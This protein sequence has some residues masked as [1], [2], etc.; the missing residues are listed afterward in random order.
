MVKAF[1]TI[2]VIFGVLLCYYT[3]CLFVNRTQ[4]E[5]DSKLIK[6]V[7]Y[8]L[9]WFG[10]CALS[11]NSIKDIYIERVTHQSK[12]GTYFTFNIVME[13]ID[14]QTVKVMR[15]LQNSFQ[16]LK[17]EQEVKKFLRSF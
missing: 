6:A 15:G 14:D 11:R 16:A 3:V 9:P 2:H 10:R 8:P 17:V 1:P 13:L 12:G 5:L 4:L 7:F